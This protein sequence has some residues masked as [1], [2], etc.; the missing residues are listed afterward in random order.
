M[1]ELLS[2]VSITLIVVSVFAFLKQVAA[3]RTVKGDPLE[4]ASLVRGF[5]GEAILLR[6]RRWRD[7]RNPFFDRT[8]GESK[9]KAALLAAAVRRVRQLRFFSRVD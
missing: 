1:E 5:S 6:I 2:I 3:W 9:L 8:E 4:A 7:R